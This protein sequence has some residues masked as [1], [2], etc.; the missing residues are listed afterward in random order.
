MEE[1]LKI[2]RR[3]KYPSRD[4]ETY[5]DGRGAVMAGSQCKKHSW[6]M[7]HLDYLRAQAEAAYIQQSVYRSCQLIKAQVLISLSAN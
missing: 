5:W 7:P 2:L 1:I 3:M 6:R 4:F